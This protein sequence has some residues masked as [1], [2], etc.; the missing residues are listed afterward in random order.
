MWSGYMQRL[1]LSLAIGLGILTSAGVTAAPTGAAQP[2]PPAP[3]V[4]TFVP[5]EVVIQFR[6]NASDADRAGARARV[7]AI[8]KDRVSR[9]GRGD[10]ELA[11]LPPGLAI[12]DA[13]R[14]LHGH[15][16][17]AFAEPNFLYF[18]D[19][20]SDDPYYTDGSLWG[21]YG[22]AT[23]PTNP[24]GS[25]AGEA[26]A[27]G[28]TGSRS[29]E[30]AVI[31]YGIDFRH[32]DLSTN[33]WTNPY[34][35]VDG[36][37]NDGNCSTSDRVKTD[38]NGNEYID[39]DTNCDS[40]GYVDDVHGWDFVNNDSTVYDPGSA[41]ETDG[42]ATHVAGTI[43]AVGGNGQGVVGVNWQVSIISIKYLG[44]S[45]TF[46]LVKALDYLIDLKQRHQLSLVATNTSYGGSSY[47][48]SV[49]AA[50][51]RAAKADI[52]FVAAAG[53]DGRDTDSSPVYPA[54]YS[55]LEPVVLDTGELFEAPA[56]YDNVI[57]VA[58]LDSNGALRSSSNYGRATVDLGAPG[59]GIYSTVP[60]G[61]YGSKSGT[62]MA[63]PHVTGAAALYAA[64]H[65]SA[66]GAEI[67]AAIL[68]STEPTASLAGITVTGGRLNI[69][70][71][72]TGGG[73]AP[74]A[75]PTVTNSP[76]PTSTP[77]STPTTPGT[78]T[79][80]RTPTAILTRTP[81]QT[82]RPT[83]TPRPTKTPRGR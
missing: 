73:P 69:D 56:S 44:S 31:D 78:P 2:M 82:P 46:N 66:G 36:V 7:G 3:P 29:V 43:G 26:W 9:P 6:A 22:D 28:F 49:H 68:G 16:A 61:G 45:T 81:T 63:A 18:A 23:T 40:G 71:L 52:L 39:P 19:A 1:A 54:G 65:P 21:M 77:T 4:G 57:A 42:H 32:P 24:Y 8:R 83:H 15:P 17:V 53:N 5:G 13:V 37:N 41:D 74:T 59:G 48:K 67:R 20:T 79:A 70:R 33:I 34:D 64:S 25:Q 10:L 27:K 30:V 50:I 55:S 80:T 12:A 62:S 58:A 51:I 60:N 47:S 14:T 76:L 75:T 72:M 38:P 11:T 35:P